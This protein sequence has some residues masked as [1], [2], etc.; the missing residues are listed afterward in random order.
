MTATPTLPGLR[1][2]WPGIAA[3]RQRRSRHLAVFVSV[4]YQYHAVR[5]KDACVTAMRACECF[6]RI[7]RAS[8]PYSFQPSG[9]LQS[10]G[11][12]FM[13]LPHLLWNYLL[14]FDNRRS[15]VDLHS[16]LRYRSCTLLS[17]RALGLTIFYSYQL[18]HRSVPYCVN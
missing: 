1:S 9:E 7:C 11:G 18:R 15:S 3:T 16:S 4:G 13:I 12:Q 10:L 6:Q 8:W 5:A 14:G 2:A 17:C